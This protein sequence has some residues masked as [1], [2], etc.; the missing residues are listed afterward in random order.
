MAKSTEIIN[1]L[2][3]LDEASREKVGTAGQIQL[4]KKEDE[5]PDINEFYDTVEEAEAEAE[6]WNQEE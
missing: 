4:I 6:V 5:M 3:G 1:H 2:E